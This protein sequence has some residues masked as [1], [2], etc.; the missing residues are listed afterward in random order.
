[1]SDLEKICVET[2]SSFKISDWEQSF[3]KKMGFPVSKVSHEY[4]LRRRLAFRNERKVYKNTC[5]LS[6]EPIISIYSPDKPYKVYSQDAWWGDSWNPKDYGRDYDFNRPFFDQFKDLEDSVPHLSL[7]NIKG[8]NSAYC[9]FTASNKNCY[10][11]FGGDFNEDCMYSIFCMHCTDCSDCYLIENC[12]LCYDLLDCTDCYACKYSQDCNNCNNSAFLYECRG[13]TNCFGCVGLANKEYYILN[14]PY[15][16]EEYEIKIKEFGLNSFQSVEKMK[17]TYTNFRLQFPHRFA[18][19]IN[20]ENCT[21]DNIINA[22]NCIDCFDLFGPG[23]DLWHMHI[24]GWELKDSMRCNHLGHGSELCYEISSSVRPNNCA[25]SFAAWDSH[26]VIYSKMIVNNSHDIF[27]CCQMKKAKYCIL[28]KQYSKDE[29]FELRTRIVEHMKTTGEWGEFFPMKDSPFCYNETVANDLFPM[30]KDEA[31]S[32]GLKWMDEDIKEIGSGPEFTDCIEDVTND[33]FEKSF[34]CEK[35]GRPFRINEKELKLYK[36]LNAPLPH[37]APETRND[38]RLKSRKARKSWDRHC[39]KCEAPV[40]SSYSPDRP[41][42]IY[43]EKC[44]LETIE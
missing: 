43:C 11:V 36:K 37:Y 6:G 2:G 35:T 39:E 24:A 30:T 18:H 17:E 41:E 23:E 42:Q 13:C 16:K 15:S 25:F 26:D 40:I 10:L 38:I 9:H 8:D 12:E 1:M 19:L 20:C 14:K 34:I 44:F 4:A 33:V 29:Y 31:L 28:N 27:G 3:L 21:G 32:K 22:K 5:A 7:C